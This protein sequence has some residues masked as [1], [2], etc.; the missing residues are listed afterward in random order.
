LVLR[1]RIATGDYTLKQTNADL[2]RYYRVANELYFGNSLPHG[3]PIRFAKLKKKYLGRTVV[4]N[5]V[6]P[7][8][9]E[10]SER[11]RDFE[12][13]TVMTVMHEMMHVQK[14][15]WLGHDWRFDER[16]RS[17]VNMGAFDGLW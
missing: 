11:L 16:M 2:R 9:I 7:A 3:F 13:F 14:P 6:V 1:T 15:S 4:L 10:I 8:Y 17:I 5:N 12:T